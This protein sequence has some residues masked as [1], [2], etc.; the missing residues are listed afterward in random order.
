MTSLRQGF[1]WQARMNADRTKA[2]FQEEA[3]DGFL[4]ADSADGRR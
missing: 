1:G 2:F 3:E 4:T